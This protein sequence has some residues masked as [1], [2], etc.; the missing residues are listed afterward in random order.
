MHMLQYEIIIFYNVLQISYSIKFFTTNITIFIFVTIN[1]SCS[2]VLLNYIVISRQKYYISFLVRYTCN[3]FTLFKL[4]IK[5]QKY[6]C[7]LQQNEKI[8]IMLIHLQ[9]PK[10]FHMTLWE[11]TF[12]VLQYWI[13]HFEFCEFD[14]KFVTSNSENPYILNFKKIDRLQN[15]FYAQ[16][17][18]CTRC[19][20]LIFKW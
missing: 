18:T 19:N 13:R 15:I 5:Y 1:C 11:K 2:H 16:T 20:K 17:A 6:Q 14:T 8:R 9:Q 4:L 7:T 10:R 12:L 3:I